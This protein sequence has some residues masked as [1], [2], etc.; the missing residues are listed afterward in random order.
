MLK[1]ISL[2]MIVFAV[3]F[4]VIS[5]SASAGSLDLL[6]FQWNNRL[7]LLFAPARNQPSFDSLHK[8]LIDQKSE[9]EDRDLVIFE[10]LET[11]TSPIP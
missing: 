2:T 5:W 10:I 11:D 1:E 3:L 4:S 6:R 7:I 8:A 9:V